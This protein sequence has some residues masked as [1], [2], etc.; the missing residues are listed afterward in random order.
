MSLSRVTTDTLRLVTDMPSLTKQR[1]AAEGPGTPRFDL[2]SAA[3]ISAPLRV[4]WN[5]IRGKRP[6]LRSPFFSPDFI[7]AVAAVLPDV[8]LG[9][10]TQ[11]GEVVAIFP[12]QRQRGS[13]ARPVGVGI[14]DAHGLISLPNTGV[15]LLE[16]MNACKLSSF[17]FHSAP[18]EL[19]DIARFE[20][21]TTRSFLADLTVDP[22]GYENF[23]RQTSQTIDKQAQKT[24]RMIRELGPLRFDF[25]CRDPA[26]LQRLIELK[27]DQYKRTH[28]FNI[29]GVPW[30]QQLLR[31][32]HERPPETIRGILNVLYAG[33]KPV[34]LHYGMLE[35]DLL[36]YWFPVFDPIASFGSPGTQLFLEVAREGAARGVRAIDMG[37]GE[38][39][40]KTKLTNVVGE[41]S[42]GLVDENPLRRGWYQQKKLLGER[43]KRLRFKDAIKPWARKL[44]PGFGRSTYEA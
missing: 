5:A 6:E 14:N 10:A 34:A 31:S 4:R 21:G 43:L 7:S 3:E 20:L 24:R 23:L 17:P 42:Y 9:I 33:E 32:L 40:Y 38:Q 26:L 11:A 22:L 39:A 12:F 28:I 36:H 30:I 8:E 27:C 18:R 29:L 44:L 16:M 25:D 35:G 2:I 37:Y 15:S 41:M 13:T 1:T 19:A